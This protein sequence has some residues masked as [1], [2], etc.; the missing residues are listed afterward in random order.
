MPNY[1]NAVPR[2]TWGAAFA[3][4]LVFYGKLDRAG[5]MPRS[6]VDDEFPDVGV[7]GGA[8][9]ASYGEEYCLIATVRRIPRVDTGGITG[10]EGAT[11]W[12]A[13]LYWAKDANAF[14]FIYDQSS[15]G[16]Y[17]LCYLVEPRR[18]PYGEEV[19]RYKQIEGF[20][21]RRADGLP[22]EGY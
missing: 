11:G 3:N 4:S 16:V 10:W 5:S 12:N 17:T 22:F 19:N 15:L 8:V 2:I 9:G 1:T 21:I 6:K 14:R 20:T 18:G 7:D 13:F